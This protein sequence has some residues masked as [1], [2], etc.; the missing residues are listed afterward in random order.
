MRRGLER[1][2]LRT[3]RDY[4]QGTHWRALRRRL[5]MDACFTC[6][7]REGLVLH[8]ATYARLGRE[9]AA[10]LFTLCEGCH[11]AVHRSSVQTRSLVP[12]AGRA[13]AAKR[14]GALSIG[15]P[16]CSARPGEFCHTVSGMPRTAEHKERRRF[17]DAVARRDGLQRRRRAAKKAARSVG[18]DV[19]RYE[20]IRRAR[21][22]EFPLDDLQ[23]RTRLGR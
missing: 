23:R 12:P 21:E 5:A 16:L 3:Y 9:I 7:A 22:A 20:A 11:V 18:L 10:D 17:A 4:L 15:C 1:L 6:G 19:D 14:F 2:G 13:P 8:H